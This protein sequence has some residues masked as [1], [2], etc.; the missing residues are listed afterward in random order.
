MA[1]RTEQNSNETIAMKICMLFPFSSI[2]FQGDMAKQIKYQE[3]A[4]KR[5]FRI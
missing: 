1:Q 4:K 3:I 2:N 5:I